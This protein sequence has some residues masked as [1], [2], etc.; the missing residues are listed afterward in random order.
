M[1]ILEQRRKL[2]KRL[3]TNRRGRT[4]AC[5]L[6]TTPLQPSALEGVY[7]LKIFSRDVAVLAAESRTTAND[8]A[9]LV[10]AELVFHADI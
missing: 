7:L 5:H 1:R 2:Y 6:T 3:N 9:L 4:R 8:S 10:H